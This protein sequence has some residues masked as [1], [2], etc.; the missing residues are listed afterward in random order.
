M[1]NIL[2]VGGAGYV[3]GP[4]MTVMASK[5][6]NLTFHVVDINRESNIILILVII[7]FSAIGGRLVWLQ[8]L[9]GSFYK[10][11]SEYTDIPEKYRTEN[12]LTN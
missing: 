4:T 8:L 12:I 1:K 3:G 7:F 2:V 9:K 11:L 6:P 10:V 5:C